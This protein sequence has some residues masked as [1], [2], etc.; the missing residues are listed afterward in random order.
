MTTITKDC[1]GASPDGQEVKK[2]IFEMMPSDD[3]CHG[4]CLGSSRLKSIAQNLDHLWNISNTIIF[5]FDILQVCRFTLTRGKVDLSVISWGATITALKYQHIDIIS[6]TTTT[7]TKTIITS[8][9]LI[10]MTLPPQSGWRRHSAW[11]WGHGWVGDII[12]IQLV[13]IK[14]AQPRNAN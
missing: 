9:N 7:I 3:F 6:I 2:N 11:L 4:R 8:Q 14:I 13:N 10:I 1:F 12:L 5:T